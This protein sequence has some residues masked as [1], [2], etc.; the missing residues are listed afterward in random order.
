[1]AAQLVE[2]HEEA[3]QERTAIPASVVLQLANSAG[4]VD[5]RHITV[6]EAGEGAGAGSSPLQSHGTVE[7]WQTLPAPFCQYLQYEDGPT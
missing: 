2:L 1:M 7:Y 3:R 6:E 4:Q 5:S